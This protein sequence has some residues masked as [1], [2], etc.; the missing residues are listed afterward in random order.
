MNKFSLP[1]IKLNAS[2]KLWLQYLW[3]KTSKNENATYKEIRAALYKEL[4]PDF[5]PSQINR[6]LVDQNGERI[7]LLGI[8]AIDPDTDLLSKA[9]KVINCI[10][11]ILIKDFDR[12][13]VTSEEVG[14]IIDIN[15][16]EVGLVLL[17]LSTYGRFYQGAS[18]LE[19]QIGYNSIDIA[20]NEVFDQYLYFNSIEELISNYYIKEKNLLKNKQTDKTK[21]ILNTTSEIE[22]KPIFNS[23]ISHVDLNLCFVLMPF[24]QDWSDRVYKMLL[25]ETIESLGLQCIR[26]DNLTGTIIMEDIWTKIN[27]AAFI[28]ADVTERNPNVM[29]E[30][31]IVHSIGKP[32]ILITQDL[33]KIPFD[34]KHLRHYDYNDN[35]ESF[36]RFSKRLKE[37]VKELY[38]TYY[39]DI[40][41]RTQ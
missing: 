37:I 27:Q 5:H 6:L 12:Q 1:K 29:Y 36:L 4:A 22:Y 16:Q 11:D 13:K 26:A 34:F 18:F 2:E 17:L 7:T 10:K 33:K 28:V 9:N 8:I 40:I 30:L 20:T 25:R 23:R 35:A 41:L 38:K 21:I 24:G 19:K 39:P 15:H 14:N 32:A 3:A 31:G